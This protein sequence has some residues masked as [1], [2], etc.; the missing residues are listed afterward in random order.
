M[1][2]ADYSIK[3][4]YGI[5]EEELV[6]IEEFSFPIDFVIIDIPEDEETPII[7]GPPFMR[8]SRCN[9]DID[10]STLTLKVYDDEV[11]KYS[12]LFLEKRCNKM[13]K[14]K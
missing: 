9:F 4:A 14:L 1:K 7:L 5:M 2:F 3:N 10:H 8:T 13:W 6:T 11:K 12:F